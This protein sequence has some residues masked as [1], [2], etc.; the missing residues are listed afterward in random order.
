MLC[1]ALRA[2][3]RQRCCG[4]VYL[5]CPCVAMTLWPCHGTGKGMRC[6]CSEAH[7]SRRRGA[8]QQM[9]VGRPGPGCDVARVVAGAD[10]VRAAASTRRVFTGQQR[11]R[12]RLML[13]SFAEV[14]DIR[15]SVISEMTQIVMTFEH[16]NSTHK[17]GNYRRDRVVCGGGAAAG[18]IRR[19]FHLDAALG[20]ER[21][22]A[23]DCQA[24]LGLPGRV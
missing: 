19:A 8:A 7:S 22:F 21:K 2:C 16:Q 5:L 10:G 23:L 6:T 11:M 13:T 4:A 17:F 3:V 15:T 20:V 9:W 1:A 12:A 14:T 24:T 18:K